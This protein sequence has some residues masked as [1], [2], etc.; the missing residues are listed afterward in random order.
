MRE[1]MARTG[2]SLPFVRL[3][4]WMKFPVNLAQ[5]AAGYVSI[6]FSGADA[7]VTEEFLDDAQVG[8]VFEQM[9]GETLAQHVRGDIAFDTG[10]ADAALDAQPKRHRREGSAAFGEEDVGGRARFEQLGPARVKVA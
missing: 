5:P 8:A 3:G 10:A 7:G 6:N 9:S 4:P 1:S 2:T